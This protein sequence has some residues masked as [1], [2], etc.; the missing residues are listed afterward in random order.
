MQPIRRP[1]RD[2]PSFLMLTRQFLPGYF[3]ARLTALHLLWSAV[4]ELSLSSR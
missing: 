3:Q 4:P 2:C 1:C